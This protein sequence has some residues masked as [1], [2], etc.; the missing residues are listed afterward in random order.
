V[1]SGTGTSPVTTAIV[2]AAATTAVARATWV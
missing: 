1:K 2:A